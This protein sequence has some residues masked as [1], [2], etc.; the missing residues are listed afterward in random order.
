MSR[1]SSLLALLG[2]VL[3][4]PLVAGCACTLL[5]CTG[6][7][8]WEATPASGVVEG[9]TYRFTVMVEANAAFELECVVGPG[10]IPSGNCERF[11]HAED[12]AFEVRLD[13]V[14][15]NIDV[16][17]ADPIEGFYIAVSANDGKNTIGPQ[18]VGIV[19]THE[20]ELLADVDYDVDYVRDEEYN[21]GPHCGFCDQV[22]L[23]TH[24]W[25]E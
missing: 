19:M 20:G 17:I 24:V 25:P 15:P 18:Q 6:G 3:L 10:S 11:D 2:A 5:P 7:F 1:R 23:R 9:G 8:V 16:T 21:G 13:F 14:R 12:S 4:S 22:E